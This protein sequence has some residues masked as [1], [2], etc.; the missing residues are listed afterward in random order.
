MSSSSITIITQKPINSQD[1]VYIQ[2]PV[3]FLETFEKDWKMPII[4]FPNPKWLGNDDFKWFVESKMRSTEKE[5][6]REAANS[7]I[8]EAGSSKC[9]DG[10]ALFG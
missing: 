10:K 2:N 8:R 5:K 3:T 4:V 9:L 7:H 6:Q 1:H